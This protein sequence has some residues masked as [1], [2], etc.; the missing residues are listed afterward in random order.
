VALILATLFVIYA[1]WLLAAILYPTLVYLA[2]ILL[3]IALICF[4]F[5]AYLLSQAFKTGHEKNRELV[6]TEQRLQAIRDRLDEIE[7]EAKDRDLKVNLDGSYHRGSKLGMRLNEELEELSIEQPHLEERS[8]FVVVDAT[9]RAKY[10]RDALRGALPLYFVSWFLIYLVNPSLLHNVDQF[11]G[12]NSAVHSSALVASFVTAVFIPLAV[13]AD[14]AI[15]DSPSLLHPVWV[16]HSDEVDHDEEHEKDKEEHDEDKDANEYARGGSEDWSSDYQHEREET[17]RPREWFDILGVTPDASR[18]QIKV[19]RDN[20]ARIF[21][22][23]RFKS[24]REDVQRLADKKLAEVNVAYEEALK[25]CKEDIPAPR[26]DEEETDERSLGLEDIIVEEDWRDIRCMISRA[27]AQNMPLA[28]VLFVGKSRGSG[29]SAAKAIAQELGRG[30]RSVSPADLVYPADMAAAL[31]N[32]EPGDV[33]FVED[34]HKL[35]QPYF[36]HLCTAMD[37][38]RLF[39]TIGEDATEKTVD[40]DLAPFTAI[41]ASSDERLLNAK[42]RKLFSIVIHEKSKT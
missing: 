33:L 8:Y 35:E 21:H 37:G 29:A 42:L 13:I 2:P 31:T 25:H 3:G 12:M 5:R 34:V 18:S 39:M 26:R 16:T 11:V 23:D 1:V 6:A 24:E 32:I 20:L 36:G 27:R 15:L 10:M 19:A 7:A 28:H 17:E 9:M 4:E 40:I 14:V 30:I 38:Y 22:S 41:G